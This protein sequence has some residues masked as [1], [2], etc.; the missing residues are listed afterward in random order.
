MSRPWPQW[1][2]RFEFPSSRTRS[3]GFEPFTWL[4]SYSAKMT[5]RKHSN[6]ETQNENI[7]RKRELRAEGSACEKLGPLSRLNELSN[8]NQPEREVQDDILHS[9]SDSIEFY[10][11]HWVIHTPRI[12][13]ASSSPKPIPGTARFH[14]ESSV[15]SA[16]FSTLT[17]E[18]G[19]ETS[20]RTGMLSGL[21]RGDL[22]MI[23]VLAFSRPSHDTDYIN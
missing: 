5:M 2:Q 18:R 16:A 12:S 13:P 15:N 11:S 21:M 23:C 4:G 3:R 17:L 14:F 7:N 19:I 9:L 22:T 10:V 1:N 8:C 20:L 6:G